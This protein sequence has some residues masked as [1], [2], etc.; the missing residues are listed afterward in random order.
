M[1]E[2]D[3]LMELRALDEALEA[4]AVTAADERERRLQE[5]ALA[6]AAEAVEP[7]REFARDLRVRVQEGFPRERRRP[8]LPSFSLPSARPSLPVLGG[9]ASVV[10][11]LVVTVALVGGDEEDPERLTSGEA[12]IS[13]SDSRQSRAPASTAPPP[14]E[15]LASGAPR[16]RIERSA[17]LT[18]AAP[19]DEIDSTAE[20]IVAVTDRLR[21]FVLSSSVSTGEDGEGGRFELRVPAARLAV[22]LKDL[23]ALGDV[24]SRTQQ[25][26]D[27][28]REAVTAED[29]LE[30]ARAERRSL[31][32]R[33]ER[34]GSDAEAEAIRRRLDLNAGEIR[35]LRAQVRDIR[36]R[37]GYA[38]VSVTLEE[39]R[40]D[41]STGA[42]DDGLGGALD[43]ALRSIGESA[44]IAVRVLGVALPL[45]LLGA[46][47]WGAARFA[48]RRSREA[49]LS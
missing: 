48:L 12:P 31:L 8:R 20:R 28:T 36:L 44:E 33:L 42:S 14:V 23:S 19:G 26:Q 9:V 5:L 30:A 1:S 29:R 3:A 49:A 40:G 16:R 4:G 35:G 10:L 18:L 47:G 38:T 7:E 41:G 15:E 45:A 27:V 11:A 22:A 32:R 13:T 39:K 24:R 43:D 21:G 2:P 6:L 34:A 25:G 46:L 37:T 17:S